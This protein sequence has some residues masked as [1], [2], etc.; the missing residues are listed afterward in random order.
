MT[1]ECMGCGKPI[2]EMREAPSGSM[3]PRCEECNAK[4]WKQFYESDTEQQGA[5]SEGVYV[6]SDDDPFDPIDEEE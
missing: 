3:C 2:T 4:R 1:M 5:V 6:M